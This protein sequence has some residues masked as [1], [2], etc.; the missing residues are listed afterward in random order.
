MRDFKNASEDVKREI[1]AQINSFEEKRADEA[2]DKQAAVQNQLTTNTGSNVEIKP[3][4]ENTMP[5]NENYF[6][7]HESTPVEAQPEAHTELVTEG[8]EGDAPA[9]HAETNNEPIKNS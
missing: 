1:N 5:I 3:L 7:G 4:V 9:K 2:L 8:H 6:S